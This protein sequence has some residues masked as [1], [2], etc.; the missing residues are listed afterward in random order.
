MTKYTDATV[1]FADVESIRFDQE[2]VEVEELEILPN[3]WVEIKRY[4]NSDAYPPGAIVE[5][6]NELRAS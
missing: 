2:L 5:I 6:S 3:G 1:R 4:G